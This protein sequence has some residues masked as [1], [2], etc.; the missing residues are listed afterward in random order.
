MERRRPPQVPHVRFASC[1]KLT[2]DLTA[3]IPFWIPEKH[4]LGAGCPIQ[5]RSL[6]LSGV[7]I[8]FAISKPH[9][10]L[11]D[12]KLEPT[13]GCP[14]QSRSLRLSGVAT[15]FAVSSPPLLPHT[16]RAVAVSFIQDS[17][18]PLDSLDNFVKPLPI[19]SRQGRQNL[20]RMK[21]RGKPFRKILPLCRRPL[22]RPPRRQF[23]QTQQVHAS[24]LP[25]WGQTPS[26]VQ[27][28]K[29]PQ[30]A[31]SRWSDGVLRRCPTFVSRPVRN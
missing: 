26:S 5:S 2:W 4:P 24:P 25:T 22:S 17:V 30:P 18:E 7:A 12:S 20:A 9:S 14:I 3:R 6:R 13:V 31:P 16:L 8:R 1:A 29:A 27:R 19:Q 15:R 21:V 28:S 23:T 11:A 10:S